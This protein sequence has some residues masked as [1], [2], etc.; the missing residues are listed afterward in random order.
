MLRHRN[1]DFRDR[2]S[3]SDQ[4]NSV[5]NK[6]N[7]VL[8][9]IKRTVGTSNMK[10]FMLLYKTLVRPILEYAVPMW[11]PY[12]VKDVKA[13]ES[14]QRRASRMAL[15]KKRGVNCFQHSFFV[16][17]INL[18]NGLSAPVAEA[19]RLSLFKSRLKEHMDMYS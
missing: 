13:L 11:S 5:V 9:I 17:I 16:R 12:L 10:V 1:Q 6:A 2:H 18:W 19:D 8:G 14:V 3:W 7:R 4:V 15:N